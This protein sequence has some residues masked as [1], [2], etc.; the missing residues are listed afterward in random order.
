MAVPGPGLAAGN[1]SNAACKA[2][3]TPLAGVPGT[4]PLPDL[5]RHM[6]N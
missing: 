4:G 2:Q 1:I 3:G 6:A 5:P